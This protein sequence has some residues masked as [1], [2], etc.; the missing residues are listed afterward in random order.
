MKSDH[1]GPVMGGL[2]TVDFV[3]RELRI[4]VCVVEHRLRYYDG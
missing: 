1:S 3:R 2:L 4:P